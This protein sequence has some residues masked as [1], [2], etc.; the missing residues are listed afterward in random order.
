MRQ[1]HEGQV[2]TSPDLVTRLLSGQFPG[3]L[4]PEITLVKSFGTD[5]DIYRVGDDLCVRLPKIEWATAQADKERRWLPP[6]A[7]RLPVRVPRQLGIGAPAEGYPF[8]WSVCEWIHGSDANRARV[9]LDRLADDLAAFV[10]ALSNIATTGA[11]LRPAGARGCPL[12]EVDDAV[13]RSIAALGNDRATDE[14][15]HLW[16]ESLGA[17]A[18]SGKEVWVH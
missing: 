8:R 6:L 10:T 18:W 15:R 12:S 14:V 11:P 7:N 4:R 13:R 5:H 2:V 16:D 1:M 3:W 17:A 9:D